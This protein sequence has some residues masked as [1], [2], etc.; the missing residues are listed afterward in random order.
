MSCRYRQDFFCIFFSVDS[1]FELLPLAIAAITPSDICELRLRAGKPLY[2][3]CLNRRFFVEDGKS[4]YVVTQTD[5]DYIIGRASG[6]SLYSVEDCLIKGFLPWLGGVRIGVGGEG[7]TDGERLKGIKNI[8]SLN[9][10]VPHEIKGEATSLS[11]E[12]VCGGRFLSTL[13][14]SPPAA[15]KTT[16]LRELA[17]VASENG[18][19]TTVIDERYELTAPYKGVPS[20]DV[21]K[22]T[23]IVAGVNKLT[24]YQNAVRSL[25]P[26]VI[27]TD[28][29]YGEAEVNAVLDGIRSGVNVAASVHAENAESLKNTVYQRLAEGV[30]VVV[31]LS[32][33]PRAGTI[34][35]VD[36]NV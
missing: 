12:I 35:A 21:G 13:I 32:K 18:L 20:L 29:I 27:I 15:G 30:S 16:L 28:E 31:T 19:N 1:L 6:Y 25:S 5:I 14:I 34:V 7:V 23:D 22:C 3:V 10:R 33:K 26:D 8:S 2:A 11:D 4:P 9:I 17:R 36:R 24:A